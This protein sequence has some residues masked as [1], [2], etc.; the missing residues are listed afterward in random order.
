MNGKPEIRSWRSWAWA[1][2]PPL[3]ALAVYSNT[4]DA[5]F[6]YDDVQQIVK[7][8]WVKELRHLP[9]TLTQ[10]VWAFHTAIPTNYYR[11]VQ[12]GLYNLLWTASGGT[13]FLFHAANVLLH[14]LNTLVFASLIRRVST[15]RTTAFGAALLFAVHP[16][17][18]EAVAWIACVP[19]L[20]Y[21]LL[22]LASLH[23]H[24]ASWT[25]APSRRR[26]FMIGAVFVFL[27]GAFSKETA[28]TS[29]VLVFFLEMRVR[30]F[31]GDE[32]FGARTLLAE[33][34]R[35]LR[36]CVPYALAGVAYLLVRMTVVGGVAPLS[37]SNLGAVDALINAPTLL[38]SYMGKM[39]APRGLLAH[40]VFDPLASI[41]DIRFLVGVLSVG[42]AGVVVLLLVWRRPVLAFAG[43][44]ACV[45]LL[46]V[47]YLP[48]AG[49]S[50]FAER[51]AYLPTAGMTW[52]AVGAFAMFAARLRP[53]RWSRWVVAASLVLAIPAA[54]ATVRRN[55]D[56]HDDFRL[57]T[58]MVATEP[59]AR[60]GYSLLGNWHSN[61]DDPHEALEVY[62][63]GLRVLP[64]VAAFKAAI[65]RL[66]SELGTL[67]DRQA[68][69]EYRRLLRQTPDEFSIHFNLGNAYL[70]EGRLSEAEEAFNRS[71]QVRPTAHAAL[72]AMAVI[73]W[74]RGEFAESVDYCRQAVSIYSGDAL[75][76]QQLGVGLLE[77]GDI[78]GAVAAL[79]KAVALEPDD[80]EALSRLGV[81]YAT[82]RRGGD[83]RRCWE[84]ALE[85]DPDFAKARR[86]LERLDRLEGSKR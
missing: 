81:A 49:A 72:V 80:K 34:P 30:P 5:E 60:I 69:D 66:R 3:A 57:A 68:I 10:P 29:I 12:M 48:A 78:P 51:Y 35:A 47:L 21:T 7:N 86:N 77:L 32:Q 52:L 17:N 16:L 45:P 31:R 58:S 38:A 11:P 65:V 85:I 75:A 83:A 20:T 76:H 8:P 19:E 18:T 28:L 55:D 84:K 73:A 33:T 56:W 37:R 36:S 64:D 54:V 74:R 23:L 79:E 22:V 62:R 1:V 43:L 25:A 27:I 63:E 44:M 13:P 24:V 82:A 53:A 67:S 14:V 9:H 46:P 15:D 61:H 70:R 26:L 71:L 50:A 2:V 42:L 41:S 39:I 40:H 4:L 59:R 6:V